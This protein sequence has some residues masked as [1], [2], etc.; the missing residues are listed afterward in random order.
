MH[1]QMLNPDMD[2]M[3]HIQNLYSI[4]GVTNKPDKSI[5]DM[6]NENSNNIP[7]DWVGT[8]EEYRA[9]KACG[10]ITP[11]MNCYITDDDN[12]DPTK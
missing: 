1:E 5:V 4:L 2:V 6:V 7:V 8:V 9:A 10:D 12:F 11:T 3:Q